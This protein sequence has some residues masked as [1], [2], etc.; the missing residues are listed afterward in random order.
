MTGLPVHISAAKVRFPYA[1]AISSLLIELQGDRGSFFG[2]RV[3]RF[4]TQKIGV[5]S[6]QMRKTTGAVSGESKG[7]TEAPFRDVE[8]PE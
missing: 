2:L 3:P 1:F 7:V 4:L 6:V 5:L 8:P